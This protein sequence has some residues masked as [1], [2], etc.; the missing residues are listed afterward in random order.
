MKIIRSI[1]QIK[2]G[3]ADKTLIDG[4]TGGGATCVGAELPRKP[5]QSGILPVFH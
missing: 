1:K 4:G 5:R 2:S 3:R